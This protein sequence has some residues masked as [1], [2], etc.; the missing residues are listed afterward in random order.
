[1][2]VLSVI[3][4]ILA[5]GLTALASATLVLAT[6][7]WWGPE[8][9]SATAF[10]V[11]R[12]RARRSFSIIVP[13][14]HEP[15]SVMT[16]TIESLLAQRVD[17]LQI[18]I[19]VGH[20]DP[21]TVAIA[22][23]LADAHPDRVVV[24]VD[25]A[26]VKNKPRQLNTALAVCTGEVVGVF[27]AESI[28]APG[29]LASVDAVFDEGV[30]AVQGAVHLMNYRSRWFT[31]RNCLEYFVWFRS[32]LHAHARRRFVTLGG[33]TVFL[34]RA[35]LTEIGGWDA[36][37]LA[38]DCDLGVRLSTR[39]R[40]IRVAYAP[41]LVTREEAPETL[42]ALIKQRTRWAL[43]FMQVLRKGEWKQLPTRGERLNAWWTLTQQHWMALAGLC[44]PV[45]VAVALVAK[46]PTPITLLT[47]IP[48]VFVVMTVVLECCMLAEF[49]REQNVPI[50]LR[51]VAVLIVSTPLYQ[52]VLA[53][54]AIRAFV[55]LY[56]GD[57]RWE[58]TAHTGAHLQPVGQS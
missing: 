33:N 19:S 26:L 27:D 35:L 46:L 5:A 58:K 51:D 16:A 3:V 53:V 32:R 36:D 48:L 17:D 29:L 54:A 44:M 37:C 12:D 22:R 42:H 25:Y 34:S 31:L 50:G 43:G 39:R 23:R 15:E 13:C 40:R 55:K 56:T 11:T 18:V 1:M 20:D 2:I 49:G 41:D 4:L 30:D 7:A 52:V 57:L 47:F 45:A 38:E 10:P 24:S 14:R 8:N 21:D 9:S 6:F 28:A